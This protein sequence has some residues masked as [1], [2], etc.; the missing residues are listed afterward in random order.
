MA[1]SR[2]T[3]H[4]DPYQA[5]GEQDLTAHVNWTALMR[6][7]EELGLRTASLTTQMRFLLALGIFER[8][9]AW[10]DD[11]TLAARARRAAWQ[12]AGPGGLG[13]TFQVL[14]QYKSIETPNLRGLAD[15]YVLRLP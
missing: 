9:A 15:P 4:A 11:E 6:R 13:E 1:Y 7:G 5:V 3:A 8:A 12:L 14:V 2:H 10:G